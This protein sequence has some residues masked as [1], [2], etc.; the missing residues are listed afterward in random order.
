MRWGSLGG[1]K[2]WHYDDSGTTL[3][4]HADDSGTTGG[5]LPDDPA[6]DQD[7]LTVG[8]SVWDIF[9]FPEVLNLLAL[10]FRILMAGCAGHL[11]D[12][13]FMGYRL[14]FLRSGFRSGC[15]DDCLI[16]VLPPWLGPKHALSRSIIRSSETP[17]GL[18]KNHNLYRKPP[19]NRGLF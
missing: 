8:S 15:G 6:A 18:L 10:E 9:T 7:R 12:I 17:N 3:W 14:K 16:M 5:W 1:R 11:A 4:W 13:V 2:W 19:E